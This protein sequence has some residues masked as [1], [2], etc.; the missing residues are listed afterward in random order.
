VA[1]GAFVGAV[2]I[3]QCEAAPP[4]GDPR[5]QL[6]DVGVPVMRIMSQSDYLLGIAA[7]RPDGDTPA[8]RFRHY[9]MA[10]AGHAT[11]DEVYYSAA[12]ADIVKAGRELPPAAC[13]QG[14]RSRFPSSIHFDAAPRNLDLWVRF[15]L[16]PPHAEP[17]AVVNGAPLLD[18]F[19]N[20]IGGLRSPYVDVP[21]SRWLGSSTG[22]SFCF[23]AG[24]EEP[25]PAATLRQLYPTH[26]AYV[27]AVVRDV[28]RLV[29]ER[30]LTRA[31]GWRLIGEAVR[32]DVPPR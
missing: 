7:R 15:G 4:T 19:G 12:P 22:A 13:D 8:D 26:R 24:H 10:G 27:R 25:L 9:E 29:R 6:R 21:T 30:F 28:R 14:P 16:A 11:P 23:I 5:R 3:N 18:A 2:P 20:V 31:D 1:G 17:I 32:A